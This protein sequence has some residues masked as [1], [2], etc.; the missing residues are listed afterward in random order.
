MFYIIERTRIC[1]FAD[2]T[3]P[4]SHNLKE[5]ITDVEDDCLTLV[6]WFRGNCII[7]NAEKCHFIVSRHKNEVIFEKLAMQKNT[8]K[9][10]CLLIYSDLYFHHH[11]KIL[12]KSVT[13]AKSDRKID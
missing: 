11:A 4:H 3:N 6:K 1:N 9:C 13:I 2:H 8:E 5:A 12:Q 10:L 7:L